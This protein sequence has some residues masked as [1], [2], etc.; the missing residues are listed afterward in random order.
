MYSGVRWCRQSSPGSRLDFPRHVLGCPM[1]QKSS[2]G[3]RLDFPR[4]V[5]GCPM[6]Q[7]VVAGVTVGFSKACT[8]VSDGA[9]SRRRPMPRLPSATSVARGKPVPSAHRRPGYPLSGCVPAEPDSV[10]PG[11][12]ESNKCW[13][14]KQEVIPRVTTGH[15]FLLLKE[16]SRFS[17]SARSRGLSGHLQK[18]PI[19]PVGVR[20]RSVPKSVSRG[21]GQNLSVK[22]PI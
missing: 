6:V 14:F 20:R 1:V 4:H 19:A 15:P 18:S 7:A 13:R 3:L 16:V 21:L 17:R 5:L 22:S 11:D 2:P 8:R 12:G 9:S 10:S